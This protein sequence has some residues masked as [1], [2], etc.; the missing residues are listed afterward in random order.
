MRVAWAAAVPLLR[1]AARDRGWCGGGSGRACSAFASVV[2]EAVH[3]ASRPLWRLVTASQMTIET[4]R[5]RIPSS[6][7]DLDTNMRP[8]CPLG[9]APSAPCVPCCKAAEQEQETS[10]TLHAPTAAVAA[11][12]HRALA[13]SRRT[14]KA[15]AGAPSR[16]STFPTTP[17]GHTNHS[18]LS[19][20]QHQRASKS[21]MAETPETFAFR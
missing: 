4:G 3:G 20:V 19:P 18:N 8:P 15:P 2:A 17:A 16:R 5:T 9:D 1:R 10:R 11:G 13:C 12:R 7:M 21:K 6:L 14:P